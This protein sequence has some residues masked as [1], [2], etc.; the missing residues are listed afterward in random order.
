MFLVA[1]LMGSAA[2]AVSAAETSESEIQIVPVPNSPAFPGAG[3]GGAGRG[4]IYRKHGPEEASRVRQAPANAPRDPR[5]ATHYV[6]GPLA[7]DPPY[8][9]TA[10]GR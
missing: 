7:L 8:R 2:A 10:L 1:I 9:G 5:G 3:R 6:V 4:K